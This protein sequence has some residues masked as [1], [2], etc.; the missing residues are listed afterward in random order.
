MAVGRHSDFASDL[1][2]SLQVQP[3]CESEDNEEAECAPVSV[4][5]EGS[6]EM[7]SGDILLVRI[8]DS[9]LVDPA[10]PRRAAP[11]VDRYCMR[12]EKY[13]E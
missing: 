9:R 7:Q 3:D 11:S 1:R 6:A 5:W 4:S 8:D 12:H 2:L 10:A 13:N